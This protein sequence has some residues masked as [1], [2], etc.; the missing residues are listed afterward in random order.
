MMS[1]RFIPIASLVCMFLM[2]CHQSRLA[3]YPDFPEHMKTLGNLSLISDCMIVQALRGDTDKIDLIQNKNVGVHV[4]Q[5]SAD[6]LRQKG[7]MVGNTMLSS[8]GLLMNQN[9]SYRVARTVEDQ[10]RDDHELPLGSAPFY[11]DKAISHDS[12]FLVQLAYV[13]AALINSPP[14]GHGPK[15]VVPEVVE[16]GKTIGNGALA[17]VLAGGY[18]VPVAKS[19]GELTENKS[20]TSSVVAVQSISH[21]SLV[22]F[23]LDTRTGEV[24]WEDRQ[25]KDGGMVMPEKYFSMIEDILEDLP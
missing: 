22:F 17:V 2:G 6:M 11:I 3:S 20:L 24:I 5:L 12:T 14:N 4:L 21:L 19:L 18:N 15:M 16:L 23:I 10:E 9:Q 8:I 13:Y 25:F 1:S 7:Y